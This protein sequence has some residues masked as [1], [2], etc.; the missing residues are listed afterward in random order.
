MAT[1]SVCKSPALLRAARWWI[2][3]AM[4]LCS[5][6]LDASAAEPT[7][8]DKETARTLMN[9]GDRLFAAKDYQ[10]AL[11]AYGGAHEIMGV[12]TTGIELAKVQEQ[13]GLLVEARDTLLQVTRYPKRPDEPKV[14][15]RARDDAAQRAGQLAT[16]IP[17]IVVTIS[18]PAPG[19]AVS[20]AIDG[21]AIAPAAVS[22]PR[23]VNPGKHVIV[24]SSAG[25][26]DAREE[27]TVAAG[28][29]GQ[30]RVV[31]RPGRAAAP[32]AQ[33]APASSSP[34]APVRPAEAPDRSP[35]ASSGS[36]TLMLFG[37]GL[38][39]AGVIAGSVTGLL[40]LSKKSDAEKY[41]D[42]NRCR[43]EARSDIDGSKTMGNISTISFAVGAIGA[44]LGVYTLLAPSKPDERMQAGR[45]FEPIVGLGS[46]GVRG[47]F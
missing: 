22:L 14:F 42:G 45:R 37:F 40:A 35:P 44:G 33:P 2:A 43:E 20:V 6:S 31:L 38:G 36:S 46:L 34:V 28:E 21:V 41:C 27:L 9:E 1:A 10:G 32:V 30:A 17:S 5:A 23:K 13:L 26:D 39:A 7:A 29:T 24:V 12:P 11:K 4:A 18:G 3:V 19:A 25:F 16:R 8:A 47:E 15:T